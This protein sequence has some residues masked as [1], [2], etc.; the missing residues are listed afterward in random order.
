MKRLFQLLLF[1]YFNDHRT[2]P[3]DLSCRI[4]QGE[5][6]FNPVSRFRSHRQVAGDMNIQH[7]IPCSQDMLEQRFHFCR[8]LPQNFVNGSP[9]MRFGGNSVHASRASLMPRNRN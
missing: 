1:S 7:R 5:V 2:Q 3:L 6:I 4:L 9:Q 8:K